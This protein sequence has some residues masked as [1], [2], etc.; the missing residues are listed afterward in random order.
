M[1]IDIEQGSKEWLELRRKMVTASDAA[2]LMGCGFNTPY[3]IWLK[4]LSG[5][6]IAVNEHMQRGRNLEPM[7]REY[8]ENLWGIELLPE[9]HIHPKFEGIMASLDGLSSN[10][11]LVEIKCPTAKNHDK[12]V[13]EGIPDYYF[14]Q[15]QHQMEVVGVSEMMFV[16]YCPDVSERPHLQRIVKDDSYCQQLIEKELAFYECIKT[17]TP[18]ELTAK[19][20]DNLDYDQ[21]FGKL[22]EAYRTCK[23]NLEQWEKEDDRLRKEL[24]S[25]AK[26]RSVRGWGLKVSKS[27]R[28]GNVDYTQVPQL[29]GVDL[30]PYR[31]APSQIFR[32][33]VD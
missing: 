27:F 20:C 18:P 15:V 4:K 22:V 33:T 5:E 16:S 14:S 25:Y 9:C 8:L 17:L 28:K 23:E 19:D 32:I 3:E 11:V 7:A 31:K 26:E 12:V 21:D 1:K 2:A 13:Q 29:K 24:Q 10:G 6:E 30:E